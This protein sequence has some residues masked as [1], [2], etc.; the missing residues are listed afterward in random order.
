MKAVHAVYFSATGVTKS[1]V[2]LIAGSFGQPA[3]EYD[4]TGPE[5]PYPPLRVGRDEIAVFGAPVFSGRI[6]ALAAE[7]F[8]LFTGE[9]GPAVVLT[10]YGNRAYDDA[11]LELADLVRERGFVV[12]GAAAPVGRHSLLPEYAAD[13]PDAEDLEQAG[14]FAAKCREKLAAAPLATLPEAAVG[15][16]RPYKEVPPAAWLP[17]AGAD[18]T[19]CRTCA[20]LCPAGAIPA[21]DPKSTGQDCF[22]CGRCLAVCPVG[23]RKLPE[24]LLG[25]LRE[26][27]GPLLAGRKPSYWFV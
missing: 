17:Y 22:R 15:G 14:I 16:K 11:L 21:E 1:Y 24:E 23:A 3:A 25:A 9:G 19:G 10:S 6:P 4:L 26:R 13:R 12:I 8:R 20:R 27:L 2:R 18:C 5:R 7:R